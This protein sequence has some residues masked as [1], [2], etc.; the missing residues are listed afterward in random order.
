MSPTDESTLAAGAVLL[1]RIDERSV[2][3]LK[4]IEDMSAEFKETRRD[5]NGIGGRLTTV[6]VVVGNHDRALRVVVGAVI[7]IITGL[8]IWFLTR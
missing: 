7:T 5:I 2:H 6:E 1:A 8:V 3:Q 4:L